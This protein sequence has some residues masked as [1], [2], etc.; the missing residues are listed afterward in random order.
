MG[1]EVYPVFVRVSARSCR[2]MHMR[3]VKVSLRYTLPL[4]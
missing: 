1:D 4:S 3:K 2:G